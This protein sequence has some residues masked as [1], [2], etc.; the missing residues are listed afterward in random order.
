MIG[1]QETPKPESVK[2]N[3]SQYGLNSN[4]NPGNIITQVQL[5]GDNYRVGLGHAYIITGSEEVG[6]YPRNY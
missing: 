2:K 1:K 5:R 6:I 4:D 3:P